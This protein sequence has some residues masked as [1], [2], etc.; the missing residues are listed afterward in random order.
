MGTHWVHTYRAAPNRQLLHASDG[1]LRLDGGRVMYAEMGML[2]CT[3]LDDRTSTLIFAL[4]N[5]EPNS[6]LNRECV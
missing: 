5:L 6:D 1:R 2:R 4:A 3:I